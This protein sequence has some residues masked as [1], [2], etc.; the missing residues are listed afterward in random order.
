MKAAVV[1]VSDRVSRG[2]AEDASGPA[3]GEALQALGFDVVATRVI[4]DGVDSVSEV[5][6]ALVGTVDLVVTTGGTGFSPRDLT[7][8][9]T[10][11]VI[12]RPAPGLVEALRAATFGTNPHGMLSRA[13]AGIVGTTLV[14]NLPGSVNG[15]RESLEV[16][17]RALRHGVELLSDVDSDHNIGDSEPESNP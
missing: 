17:G 16:I 7:P 15:V 13:V 4:A 12:E 6:R 5:L 9:G 10:Q 8:E 3:A 1:T 14:V 11:Q 2:E